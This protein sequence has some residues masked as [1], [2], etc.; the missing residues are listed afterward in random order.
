MYDYG[1]LQHFRL[2]E[3]FKPRP[4]IFH[5]A[6]KTRDHRLETFRK[7]MSYLERVSKKSTRHSLG[8]LTEKIESVN[9]K[10]ANPNQSNEITAPTVTFINTRRK[11]I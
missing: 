6:G 8:N 7:Y 5:A 3:E 2:D 10:E 11:P 4:Y 9:E 1:F